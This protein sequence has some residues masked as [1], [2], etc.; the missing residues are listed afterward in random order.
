[1]G[2][3]EPVT[4]S[5]AKVQ[6]R[7]AQ[8]IQSDNF[9]TEQEQDNFDNIDP[10][11][12]REA[13]A[14]RGIVGGRVVDKEAHNNSPFVRQVMA[15]VERIAAQ[16][17]QKESSIDPIDCFHVVSLDRGFRTLYTVWDDETHGYHVDADGVTEE[18]SSEW[19]AEAYR[20]E[21]QGQVEQALM[22]RA[23][24]LISDF[25]Q[26]EY[27]SEADFSDP[28]KIGVA[29][30]TVTDDEIPV[31]VN[32]DLENF[33]LERYLDDEHLE[34]RQYSSLQGLIDNELEN[35]DFSDLI[36]VSDED[37]E[38]HRWHEP[39]EQT[40]EAIEAA[41]SPQKDAFP[42][43]VGDTLYLED[44]KPFVIESIGLFDVSLRDPGMASYASKYA[45]SERLVCG[46]CGTLY[47]RCTWTRNG[48]KRVVWRCVSRLDYGKKYC[49]NSPTLDEAPL[50][51]A[52]LAALNTAMADKNSLIRQITNAMETE[53]I[54]FPSGTMSLGDIER[55]L[56]E[57]EQQF[58]TLLE[59]ATDD[60]AAYGSQFKEILDEQTFLKEKRSGILADNNEQA[61][62]NQ[63][64]MDA[65]QT[66]ENASPHITEWDESAVRQLVETVK[67]LSKDEVAVTLKGGIEICQKIMY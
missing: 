54:P 29:Y 7:I 16:E 55:R 5:W 42:Y 14:E 32:I 13:L 46:E 43:S 45:L 58:Q 26:S 1:M 35:L 67:V 24:G 40:A 30:T 56:R 12:I 64:I 3:S 62:A 11:A 63:R 2:S 4:L 61:K 17:A 23:K 21:L 38:S 47:R 50:Q 49:H 65:A 37:V 33:Q 57:L 39:K 22:E 27:G 31:Q 52:I 8:L 60:P 9:Y 59:K 18:F 19:Q 10:V 48:E 6:R 41:P 34:T 25:C 20:L 66:L 44:G 15:D 51:Q 36:H 28:T 53:I